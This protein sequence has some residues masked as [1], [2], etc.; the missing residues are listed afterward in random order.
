MSGP[1]GLRLKGAIPVKIRVLHV[2]ARFLFST[3]IDARPIPAHTRCMAKISD[4]TPVRFSLQHCRSDAL[5]YDLCALTPT[6]IR[7]AEGATK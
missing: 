5:V 1:G 3:G 6:E 4:A 7:I 2:P